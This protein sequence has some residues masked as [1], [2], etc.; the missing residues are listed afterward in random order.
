MKLN[1]DII[2][3]KEGDDSNEKMNNKP[4]HYIILYKNNIIKIDEKL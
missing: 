4:I 1:V 2:V 3:N